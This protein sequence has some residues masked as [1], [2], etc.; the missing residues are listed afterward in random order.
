MVGAYTLITLRNR[1]FARGILRCINLSDIPWGRLDS[2]PAMLLEIAKAT[3]ASRLPAVF[4]IQKKVCVLSW[5]CPCPPSLVSCR[6]ATSI[7]YLASSFA[8]RA[9]LRS[10]CE[11]L[12]SIVLTF[13][14]ATLNLFVFF[15]TPLL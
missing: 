15:F 11:S 2:L 9:V 13:H 8:I 4:P 7:V 12:S 14:V 5:I 1:S 10:G 3:P 6:A